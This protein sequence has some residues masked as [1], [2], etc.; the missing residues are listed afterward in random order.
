MALETPPGK[1][2]RLLRRVSI[3]RRLALAVTHLG[4]GLSVGLAISCLLVIVDRTARVDWSGLGLT[5]LQL[6]IAVP[7]ISVMLTVLWFLSRRPGDEVSDAVAIE[8]HYRI[9]Q[10]ISSS[11]FVGAT[12]MPEEFEERLVS[13]ASS[14][15]SGLSPSAAI[16]LGKPRHLILV[17]C[18]L[19]A[20]AGLWWVLPT[21]DL[22]GLSEKRERAERESV[23]IEDE[24]ARLE[25]EI[26]KT[27]RLADRHAIDPETRRLLTSLG[28]MEKKRSENADPESQRALALAD[29]DQIRQKIGARK[30]RQEMKDLNLALERMREAT[31]PPQTDEGKRLKDSIK[32]GDPAQIASDLAALASKMRAGDMGAASDL[33]KL[34]SKLGNL[35]GM[36]KLSA[37]AGKD[38]LGS[39]DPKDLAKLAASLEQLA[40]L[41]KEQ[42]LLDHALGQIEF[43]E[44]E[45]ASLP[46][47]W[48]QGPPPEICPDCLAGT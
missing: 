32:K 6:V 29:A 31:E 9:S 2:S 18:L 5:L 26:K 23:R 13:D 27:A 8:R 1:I 44:Q 16:S 46:S 14:A 41:I 45:L 17:S 12:P 28:E 20:V 7:V 30:K 47:E 38:G 36:E 4:G 15:A 33:A 21:W 3:R 48:K 19:V 10:T 35:P 37:A 43:T 40:R 42:Q 22:L 11:L 34:A 39:I 25:N 24:E